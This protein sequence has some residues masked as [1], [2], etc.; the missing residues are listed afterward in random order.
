MTPFS[1]LENQLN[2]LHG[3]L[4]TKSVLSQATPQELTRLELAHG[5]ASKAL[6]DEQTQPLH[7]EQTELGK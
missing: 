4:A 5:I 7:D 6:E 1:E 2:K 3:E